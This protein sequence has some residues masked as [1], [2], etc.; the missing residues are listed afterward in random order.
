M[1]WWV[2]KWHKSHSWN[3][4]VIFFNVGRYSQVA[5]TSRCELDLLHLLSLFCLLPCTILSLGFLPYCVYAYNTIFNSQSKSL[6]F[7]LF[8]VL[9]AKK[10]LR[11]MKLLASES[12]ARFS[13]VNVWMED[14]W[15]NLSKLL[16]VSQQLCGL[17]SMSVTI[18]CYK[19]SNPNFAPRKTEFNDLCK[20]DIFA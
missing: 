13:L 17:I 11:A 7:P 19:Y 5:L 2:F 4:Y 20:L 3:N 8:S 16:W 15:G 6:D 12:L 9:S 1:V 14:W 10:G 18:L